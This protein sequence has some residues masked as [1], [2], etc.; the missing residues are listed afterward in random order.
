MTD[1]GSAELASGR[2][3]V[4]ETTARLLEGIDEQ[5]QMIARSVLDRVR[6]KADELLSL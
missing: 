4:S 1:L 3:T 2:A 5:E 6:G